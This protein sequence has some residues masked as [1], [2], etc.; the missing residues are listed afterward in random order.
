MPVDTLV[1]TAPDTA[2]IAFLQ[3]V[4]ADGNATSITAGYLCAGLRKVNE[5]QGK[6][7]VPVLPCNAFEA[8]PIGQKVKYRITLVPNA[9][10]FKAGHKMRL[11]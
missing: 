2:F 3:D 1:C 7:G 6:E 4:Y 5:E 9:R 10:R 8:V 11:I